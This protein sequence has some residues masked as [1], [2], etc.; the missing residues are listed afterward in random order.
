MKKVFIVY[1]TAICVLFAYA[2]YS[3]WTVSD[4]IKSGQWG[5]QGHSKYHK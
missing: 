3:G 4:S 2:S 5:P 1:G